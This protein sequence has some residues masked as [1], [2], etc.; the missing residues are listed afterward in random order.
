[1]FICWQIFS[2]SS[3]SNKTII[4]FIKNK[5]KISK[6]LTKKAKEDEETK[7]QKKQGE[8]EWETGKWEREGRERVGRTRWEKGGKK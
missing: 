5:V 8:R 2:W 6:L 4:Y 7:E 3:L 1:M